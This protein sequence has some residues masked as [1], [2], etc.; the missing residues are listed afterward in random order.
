MV[1][2]YIVNRCAKQRRTYLIISWFLGRASKFNLRMSKWIMRSDICFWQPKNVTQ[3]VNLKARISVFI[4]ALAESEKKTQTYSVEFQTA[5]CKEY[6]GIEITYPSFEVYSKC[7]LSYCIY[8]LNNEI[9]PNISKLSVGCTLRV[10]LFV[11]LWICD[12]NCVLRNQTN[13]RL[14]LINRTNGIPRQFFFISEMCLFSVQHQFSKCVLSKSLMYLSA[15]YH[16][17]YL[18]S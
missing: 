1:N 18:K 3:C 17:D 14:I 16:S 7:A 8:F 5:T 13:I 9:W 2:W 11:T 6:I 10:F 12:I 4:R 15:N